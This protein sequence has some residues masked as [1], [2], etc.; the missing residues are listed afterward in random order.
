MKNYHFFHGRCLFDIKNVLADV[1][2]IHFE[3]YKVV[4]KNDI[5]VHYKVVFFVM[6]SQ[7]GEILL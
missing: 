4:Y 7:F 5:A 1:T 3:I 2:N 6:N